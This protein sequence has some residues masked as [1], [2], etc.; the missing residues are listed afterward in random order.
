M[1]GKYSK[2][3]VV[4]YF[5]DSDCNHGLLGI[6]GYLRNFKINVEIFDNWVFIS[7]HVNVYN[8]IY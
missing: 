3:S 1:Y 6:F 7:F 2:Y 4:I 5:L 8:T